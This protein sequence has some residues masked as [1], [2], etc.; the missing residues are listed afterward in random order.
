MAPASVNSIRPTPRA[1]PAPRQHRDQPP[2]VPVR[3][4][5]ADEAQPEKRRDELHQPDKPELPLR[6][7]DVV[8]VPGDRRL[9]HHRGRPVD[10]PAARV[11]SEIALAKREE[12]VVAASGWGVAHR[13]CSFIR[14]G[15][16]T[17]ASPNGRP[18]RQR[19]RGCDGGE[20]VCKLRLCCV[21]RVRISVAMWNSRT[22][23][24]RTSSP[25]TP[26]WQPNSNGSQPH[27]PTPTRC[28]PATA[29]PMLVFSQGGST[30]CAEASI[31]WW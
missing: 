19:G 13:S 1:P 9:H 17:S 15:G 8:D 11:D 28:A 3:E 26:K 18:L 25:P 30:S 29:S 7:R 24:G 20:S 22:S 31:S 6:M 12:G 14:S 23:E 4:R 27:W 16:G 10:E 5:P 2:V 21:T